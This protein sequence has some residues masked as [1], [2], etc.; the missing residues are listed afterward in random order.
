MRRALAI[1]LLMFLYMASALLL[2]KADNFE[3]CRDIFSCSTGTSTNSNGDTMCTISVSWHACEGGQPGSNQACVNTGCISDCSCSCQGSSPNFTGTAQSWT[4]CNG[5]YRSIT[6]T[7]LGCPCKTATQSCDA[8]NPCC[9]G[10]DCSLLGNCEPTPT[11]TPT[12]TP[13]TCPDDNCSNWNPA[14][15]FYCFGASDECTYPSNDGC[16]PG[17][18]LQGRCCCQ[19]YTPILIDVMGNGFSLTN[20]T[21]GVTFDANADGTA[22]HLSWTMVNSDDAWL[23]LDRNGNGSIDNGR[24]LF[25]N[26]SPQPNPPAGEVRNGFLALAEYDKPANGG[27]GDGLINQNDAVFT[28][29]R[30]WQDTKHNGVSEPLELRSLQEHGV[31]TLELE[32]KQSKRTDE[33]GNLFRYRAKVKDTHGSQLGRWAWDI[34]LTKN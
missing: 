5:I 11:P 13:E 19:P 22:E 30:L 24:E 9:D 25:G 8:N 27:N 3:N 17:L 4:D 20:S 26:W 6:K 10:L 21:D 12:P 2:T 14:P 31:A 33:Y 7:C 28:S 29:L 18:Q 32:Y 1:G 23:A 34:Y 16:A 15:P